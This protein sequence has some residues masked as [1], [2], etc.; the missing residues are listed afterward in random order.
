[1]K[2]N[3]Q[4]ASCLISVR[5]LLIL[6]YSTLGFPSGASLSRFVYKIYPP[7]KV[8]HLLTSHHW[9][10]EVLR[11]WTPSI[12]RNSKYKKTHNVSATVSVSVLRWGEGD[13]YSIGYLRERDNPHSLDNPCHIT[14]AT[15]QTPD[16]T[17]PWD[18]TGKY[19]VAQWLWLAL[20]R[21]PPQ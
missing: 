15:T 18:V 20:L 1:V 12:I 5:F 19:A 6:F 4:Y 17:S 13:T 11:L 2:N 14:A 3:L 21:A 8:Q 9:H 16:A 10:S 7:Q